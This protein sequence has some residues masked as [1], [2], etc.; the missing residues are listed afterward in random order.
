[1]GYIS[2]PGLGIEPF[3]ID[4]VAFTVFGRPVAWY[5]LLI[6]FGMLLALFI[7]LRCSK[8]EGIK[9]D[10]I[11]DLALFA[12]IFGVLGSRLY[13]V[14]FTWNEFDYLVTDGSFFSNLWKTFVNII[15]IWNGGLAIYGG[16]IGGILVAVVFSKVKKIRFTKILDIL[17]PCVMI[18]QIVGRWGNFI[19]MEAYGGET[20]LPWRMG[21]LYG[22]AAT[23]VWY[24]EQ[25]VHPTFLY[26]S[27]W[28]IIG[29]VILLLL[30]RKKKFDGQNAA[31]Y[32]IWYGF[33]RMLIEGLRT[34]SL[35]L[36]VLRVS[37]VVGLVSAVIGILMYIFLPKVFPYVKPEE[38]ASVTAE[39]DEKAAKTHADE[40]KDGE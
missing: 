33:G 17:A 7:A 2:F 10:D 32:F 13:Y 22:D 5:G 6:T 16:V 1:M 28:N 24:A 20:T 31:T 15:A 25:Y 36:G 23:G 37:Q 40:T 27:L 8:K 14:I 4:K 18:G 34:D 21:L 11:V 26:E 19:N 29:F 9:T 39:A 3:H 38:A 12:I 30:Y 35:Y